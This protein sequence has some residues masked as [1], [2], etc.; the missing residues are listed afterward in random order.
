MQSLLRAFYPPQCVNCAAP[1]EVDFA[2][3]GVCWS[4]TPFIEGLVCDLCGCPLPGEDDGHAIHCDACLAAQRPWVKG[5]AAM[6]YK[7]NARQLVLALKH[8]DRPELSKAAA[9][10]LA[11]AARPLIKESP[12]IVPIPIHRTR[13]LK[14]R[15]NQSAELARVLSMHLGVSHIPDALVRLR[16]TLPHDGMNVDERYSNMQ[17]AIAPHLTKGNQLQG[18]KVI[19][20][21]DVMTSGATFDAATRACLAA[22]ADHVC[23]LSL[24]R[25]SRDA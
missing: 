12:V 19:L 11:R 22:G 8:G 6:R 15:Y 20:L 13:L 9:P 4:Q 17:G 23:V 7:G 18:R 25:V 14:R 1:T 3:C 24:A 16:R 21:D 5:R 2:L 10:W